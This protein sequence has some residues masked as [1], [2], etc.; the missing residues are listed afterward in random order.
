M[1]SCF[2][3]SLLPFL[4][5]CLLFRALEMFVCFLTQI[6]VLPGKGQRLTSN[7]PLPGKRPVSQKILHKCLFS[8]LTQS[9][10]QDA[11]RCM[12]VELPSYLSYTR[13]KVVEF[14]ASTGPCNKICELAR[15][16]FCSA[17]LGSLRSMC[18]G[19]LVVWLIP[20]NCPS[21]SDKSALIKCSIRGCS[22]QWRSQV[23]NVP[24]QGGLVGIAIK[25][26]QP[27]GKVD[28]QKRGKRQRPG[29]LRTP[30]RQ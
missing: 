9:I 28:F 20:G 29:D 22:H 17:S 13:S 8:L 27:V 5:L 4:I 12:Y 14:I 6:G 26:H 25:G 16:Y 18:S 1:K 24:C 3:F 11:P 15:I 19:T 7:L 2:N 23:Q 10:S 21:R 30:A